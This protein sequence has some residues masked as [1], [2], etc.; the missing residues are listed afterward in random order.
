MTP[1]QDKETDKAVKAMP[2]LACRKIAV[3]LRLI[4]DVWARRKF[5]EALARK[6]N[7]EYAYKDG[8]K[9]SGIISRNYLPPIGE[10]E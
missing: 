3:E 1:I 5:L 8:M 9:W 2:L 4:Q 6:I 10:K 7:R